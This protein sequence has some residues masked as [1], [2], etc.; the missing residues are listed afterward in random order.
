LYAGTDDGVISVSEDGGKNWT[1]YTTFPGVPEYTYVSDILPDRFDENVVYA[2]FNNMLNDD[3][4]PYI[5]KSSDKGKTWKP[6][7]GKLPVNGTIHTI[8]QDYK[9][10]NLLFAGSEFGFYVSFDCGNEWMEFKSGLPT[11]AVRDI[12][13]QERENDIVVGTFGRGIYILDDYTPLQNFKRDI[14]DKDGYIFPI[15]DARMYLQSNGF[16]NQGSTYFKS[17]NP[18]FGAT[19]TYY[20]KDVPKTAKAARQ[21]KEKTLF[22]KGEPI[23]QPTPSDLETES[24]EIKPYLVFTITDESGNII[25]KMYKWAEKGIARATWDF[26]YES[27]GPVTVTKYDPISVPG[28]RGGNIQAVPGT[29]RVSLSMVSKGETKELSGAV[30]FVCKPLGLSTFTSADLKSKYS[31]ISESSDFARSMYAAISYASELVEKTNAVRE[32]IHLAPA[33]TPEMAAEAER[34]NTELT[35]I[36][37]MLNGPVAKA[38]DEEIPPMDMPLINRLGEMASASYESN[39]DITPR[40]K[41]QLDILRTD[42]PPVMERIKKAGQDL[43]LLYKQLD[44]IKAPWTPGRIPTL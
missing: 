30:P 6:I 14:L 39:G 25:K 31:W 28:R 35:N 8:E 26:T 10:P 24:R 41:E 40:A 34:I 44:A 16:D 33:A 13:I 21:E 22:A 38:S 15:K 2:S 12:A 32:V 19:F 7:T 3:F 20:V 4:K 11:I 27:I 9:N 17:K 5:L 23:P 1:K 43:Q 42:F 36:L 37:F 18:E 29:Y